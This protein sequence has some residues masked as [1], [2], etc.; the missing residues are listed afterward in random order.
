M[1]LSSLSLASFAFGDAAAGYP[2]P[3]VAIGRVGDIPTTP[4]VPAL[5]PRLNPNPTRWPWQTATPYSCSVASAAFFA[6]FK[7]MDLSTSPTNEYSAGGRNGRHY[8]GPATFDR[9]WRRGSNHDT[10]GIVRL[11]PCGQFAAP[12]PPYC[13]A[14]PCVLGGATC[15]GQC[16]VRLRRVDGARGR[17]HRVRGGPV[18]KQ[19]QSN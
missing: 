7:T 12:G 9:A 8:K 2:L 6:S 1:L 18:A 15:A 3:L 11:R 13:R 17:R 4:N 19:R 10:S 14:V 5:R 16:N